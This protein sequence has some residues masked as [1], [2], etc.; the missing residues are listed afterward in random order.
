M[1]KL[2]SWIIGC[3]MALFSCSSPAQAGGRVAILSDKVAELDLTVVDTIADA[4]RKSGFSVEPLSASQLADD[5]VFNRET[6]SFLVLTNSP[7]FPISA[8]QTVMRFAQNGG[9][10]VLLGGHPFSDCHALYDGQWVK[11]GMTL[12]NG[13]WM[14]QRDA[15]HESGK[16]GAADQIILFDFEKGLR[17][18]RHRPGR[19]DTGTRLSRV[20][21]RFGKAVQMD[22]R[23]L[24]NGSWDLYEAT[25]SRRIDNTCNFIG[26]WVK[27]DAG[28]TM[29][30]LTV[31]QEDGTQ[32]VG[33]IPLTP[34][35]KYQ[36]LH[37]NDLRFH[38]SPVS[39][40][41]YNGD[42]LDLASITELII[43]LS[44][45]AHPAPGDHTICFDEI[46]AFE[47]P[48][49]VNLPQTPETNIDLF[50]D[51]TPIRLDNVS[52]LVSAAECGF[53]EL[54]GPWQDGGPI[55]HVQGF[56]VAGRSKF[57]GLLN[58]VN[59]DG[60]ILGCA[61]GLL[62]QYDGP[63]KDSC[64]VSFGPKNTR[65]YEN[66]QFSAALVSV[67]KRLEQKELPE[68]ARVENER[69]KAADA[70][71]GPFN[72]VLGT[73]A[74]H[75][76]YQFTNE[77]LLLESARRI[78][79]MG[80]NVLKCEITAR[81]FD[82]YRLPKDSGIKSLR[83]MAANEPSY[84]AV[85]EMPFDYY[86]FWAYA[87]CGKDTC[88]VDGLSEEE[89]QAQYK[90]FFDFTS[91]LLAQFNGSR[92]TFYLGHWEGDWM[93]LK[94]TDLGK[95]PS[96]TAIRGMID[97]LNVR[98][99]AIDDAKTR[100]PH[101]D[102][103]VYHYTEMVAALKSI[104][105]G[106]TLTNNVLPKTRIDYVSYSSYDSFYQETW[107]DE[108]VMTLKKSLDYI[109]SKLPPKDIPGK[110]VFIGEYGF[111]QAYAKTPFEQDRI[112]RLW[113][114]SALE[115]GCPFV[116]YW[117]LYCNTGVAGTGGLRGF[118]LINDN[119][120]KLPAYITHYDFLQNGRR[121]VYDFRSKYLRNPTLEEYRTAAIQ[122]LA[123]RPD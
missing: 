89:K 105:G 16:A 120:K 67:L 66:A 17:N 87:F 73:Q 26:L 40:R 37:K 64:W 74:F 49:P 76:K 15:V 14:P 53:D 28:T 75:A 18:W 46:S 57:V 72:Y 103:E 43:G 54:K 94:G 85:L 35:W 102:V 101:A 98:Q 38:E 99:Q 1:V 79:E 119:N 107:S 81:A 10:L 12:Y 29:A 92:K 7:Q 39:S 110:R 114:G 4:L 32:W 6:F 20:E 62:I 71:Y 70:Q 23:G 84:K 108:F 25:L 2:A 24:A 33:L 45:Y 19:K 56:S 11:A 31:C 106:K 78:S 48:I 96:D 115:W 69:F 44:A 111:P 121:F 52:R 5:H 60:K 109:E 77:S 88:W 9:H 118:W 55:D 22:I 93:L 104:T 95:D 97:W 8:S 117:Q 51:Y 68:Q 30:S 90:E 13:T 83:D 47:G 21:G 34:D 63:F 41:G 65:F 3:G 100:V 58:A 61:A 50:G 86:Q 80:S 122:W 82:I 91:Y 36:V 116:L 59:A 123:P 42:S 112:M 113:A 27:G